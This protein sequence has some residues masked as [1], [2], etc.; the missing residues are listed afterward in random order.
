M[1]E[2]KVNVEKLSESQVKLTI[3]VTAEQFDEALDRAFEKVIK[4]VKIDGFRQGKAPKSV[5]INHYGWESLY[6]DGIEFALQATYY[7]ALQ[8]AEVMPVSDPKIDS[9]R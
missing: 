4:N 7:L 5:F 1:S 6:Q 3:D 2:L 9:L 8:Q